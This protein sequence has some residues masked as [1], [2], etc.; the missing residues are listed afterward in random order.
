MTERT[1]DGK[2]ALVTG[3]GRGQ[4]RSH[5]LALAERGAN[6]I[7][8]DICA[9]IDTVPYPLA[10]PA[11]LEET[12]ALVEKL[13]QR[14]VTYQADV[15]DRVRLNDVVATGIRELDGIDIVVANAGVLA[16]GSDSE[17]HLIFEDIMQINVTGV[18]N[19]VHSA[20][21]LLIDQGRGGSVILTGSTQSFN[22]RGGNGSGA[23]EGYTASK[24]AVVGL[25][26]SFA[27][28]L[29][30]HRIRVNSLH[31]T[32]V[33]TPMVTSD[34]PR[35]YFEAGHAGSAIVNL[36]DVDVIESADVSHA[37]TWLASDA[38][39]YVTGIALP[40]DAGMLIT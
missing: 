17:D 26:R 37:V 39:R 3:A 19:T 16:F 6:I 18:R 25:M 10:T 24:H 40:I 11:E 36:L 7:A 20:A 34:K 9:P 38:A 12:A 27:H 5:C 32:G 1:L 13:D 15:R 22:G 23:A 8:I 14:V 21:S 29:A 2:V 31:P 30:P 28:W 33:A 4:G 35:A